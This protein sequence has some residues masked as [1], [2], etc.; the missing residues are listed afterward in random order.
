MK[1]GF[2]LLELLVSLLIF[3]FIL[4][5]AIGVYINSQKTKNRVDLMTQAQQ[6]ARTAIDYIIK[7]LRAAGFGID[8]DET[9]TNSPQR[10][11]V[12]ASPYEIIFNANLNPSD[13]N[14]EAPLSPKAM[15][16]NGEKPKHYTP[17]IQYK[18]GA[19]TIVYTLDWNNDG[20]I[21][22]QDRDE[23]P[24][25]ITPN[26]NDYCLIKRVYGENDDSTNVLDF[27]LDLENR[28]IISVVS[29][30]DVFPNQ[31]EGTPMFMF[32]ID[33]ND[34]D[35]L[36]LY[37]DSDGDGIISEDEANAT[38][39]ISIETLDKIERVTVGVTGV[40]PKAIR[41]S[42]LTSYTSTDVAITRNAPIKVFIVKGHVYLD[43]NGDSTYQ[44][45]EPG[46]DSFRIK[47]STGEFALT[48]ASGTWSF[49]LVPGAYSVQVTS[50]TGF[51]PVVTTNF[52]FPVTNEDL[53]FT[54]SSDSLSKYFG[55]IESPTA[56]LIGFAFED[57][58]GSG[59]FEEGEPWVSGIK[60]STI[61]SSAITI[62]NPSD[63]NVHGTYDL[64]LDA[65]DTVYVWSE[66]TESTY[67]VSFI[68]TIL[69]GAVTS[70]PGASIISINE[71]KSFYCTVPEDGILYAAIAL[72]RATGNA[73]YVRVMEPNGGEVLYTNTTNEIRVA[74]RTNDDGETFK[75][76]TA[77]LSIDGG[78]TWN[79][80]DAKMYPGPDIDDSIYIFQWVPNDSLTSP[81]CLIRVSVL[82]MGNW[83]IYDQSDN[84][85]TII[86]KAGFREIYF[87]SEDITLEEDSLL[88]TYA[89]VVPS[90]PNP[91][92]MSSMKSPT[93]SMV[94]D[95]FLLNTTVYAK[96]FYTQ[97]AESVQFITKK[98]F[99]RA[100]SIYEGRWDFYM[101]G[102][103]DDDK[104]S[105]IWFDVQVSKRD[106]LGSPASDTI[107]F[108][109]WDTGTRDSVLPYP[110]ETGPIPDYESEVHFRVYDKAMRMDTTNR[111]FIK[112]FY[113][114]IF[115]STGGAGGAYAAHVQFHFGENKLSRFYLP[116]LK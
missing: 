112:V 29:G 28:E 110:R 40:S 69:S 103:E 78:Y 97:D 59:Y 83:T 42:F 11:M 105:V 9:I 114:G 71:D 17:T 36:T 61:N 52:D 77:Y 50:R 96:P 79:Y 20:K 30:P 34:N 24:A 86:N 13:D 106:S 90:R 57:L 80:I 23:S 94:G 113:S 95:S 18:T 3:S 37:G 58:D 99:P 4:S 63:D 93:L 25:S 27:G 85:F 108:K 5:S 100:D 41:G 21:D 67:S 73:P 45:G 54:L 72:T 70:T 81:Y 66:S 64:T 16:V 48:D 87:N 35:S 76:I 7:D 82:D 92:Y 15:L 62:Y 56:H 44:S 14:S 12:Y 88:Y 8:L 104:G 65:L 74:A 33:E 68:D 32:W 91:K 26:P 51:K 38:E 31:T 43:S 107:I 60:I 2:T 55:F 89:T 102:F 116:P 75:T 1:K 109:S 98:G 101:T 46:L 47:L 22:A 115:K 53:D 6:S 84:Y 39:I 19:E 10:R 111:L 49:A